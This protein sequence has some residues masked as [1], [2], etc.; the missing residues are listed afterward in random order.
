ML[1]WNIIQQFNT[2]D[3][4]LKLPNNCLKSSVGMSD[5]MSADPNAPQPITMNKIHGL[6]KYISIVEIQTS[7]WI[8]SI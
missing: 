8:K 5:N 1:K 6:T 7:K 2:H 3:E 4:T